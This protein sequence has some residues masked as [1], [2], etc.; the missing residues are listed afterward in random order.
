M[1]LAETMKPKLREYVEQITVKSKGHNQYNCP[2]CRSGTGKNR[3]GAFTIYDND[4]KWHCHACGEG[5]DLF[6]L[7]GKYEHITDFKDQLKR[8]GEILGMETD[9]RQEQKAVKKEEPKK[10][11]EDYTAYYEACNRQLGEIN[12]LRRRGISDETADK[13]SIGY[14]RHYT[15]YTGGAA[16]TALIIPTGK[17][18]YIA[19]NTDPDA[20]K[21]QRY[22]K[23][24][25]SEIFNVDVLDTAT[26]P[27][28]VVE[29]EIDALSIIE[30]GGR[31]IGLGS[32]S[33]VSKL[34]ERMKKRKPK[35]TMI[36]S[37]DAD[38]RGKEA[39]E[40]LSEAFSEMG[41]PYYEINASGAYKDPN[42]ALMNTP[43]SFKEKIGRM[44][45]DPE[46]AE[47]EQK[48]YEYQ[49]NAAVFQLR[50][51]YNEI[52]YGEPTPAIPT[53][54]REMDRKLDGGLFPGLYTIGGIPSLGKTTV[55]LQIGDQI[56]QKGNDVLIV[57]LEMGR[58]ELI[59]KSLS[60][61]MA[62]I[63][64]ETRVDTS[65]MK[66]TRG[67]LRGA[68]NY[69]PKE[70]DLL[71]QGIDSYS[72]YAEHIFIFQGMG[73]VSAET[74]RKKVAEHT[75]YMGKAPVVIVDY[76][77]IMAPADI[78]D[79]EKRA[80][81]K[82]TVELKRISRDFNT[83]VIAIS[84]LNRSNYKTPISFE[85]FKE[86]GGIEYGS[87][88]VL[89]LQLKG[90]GE[91]SFDVNRAKKQLPREIEIVILK[92]RNGETGATLDFKFYPLFNLFDE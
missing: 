47:R 70:K 29:G 60:R 49:K 19:R 58:E 26:E 43:D 16:W 22:R 31:A 50:D 75:A 12:Y 85:A 65:Y 36:L 71:E 13:Y 91:K 80:T 35:C 92:N 20:D 67:I 9:I 17:G 25:S 39:S 52:L 46:E 45:T 23:I 11:A 69:L 18:S 51:F 89:G 8:A 5:G 66:T 28:I 27:V 53:G 30:V 84:S 59:A 32:V 63:G 62:K 82:N 86:S 44:M 74:I 76:I 72:E 83:P 33:N 48:K 15:R 21:D 55:A 73:D 88:V 2:L 68:K 81:D 61:D 40:K 42:E 54:F 4:T 10:P 1:D 87:D 56:A 57:S 64:Y 34:I 3:T 78:R 37:L 77:Q 90:V 6:D 14:D 38:D 7:I 41:I 79:S 24:G